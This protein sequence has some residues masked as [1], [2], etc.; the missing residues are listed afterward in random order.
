VV[1]E[2]GAPKVENIS[3]GGKARDR[4]KK[5]FRETIGNGSTGPDRKAG[6]LDLVFTEEQ[7]EGNR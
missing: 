2:V 3:L 1:V 4:W 7:K 5:K 6:E